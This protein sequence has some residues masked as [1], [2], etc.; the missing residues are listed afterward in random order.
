MMSVARSCD[1]NHRATFWSRGRGE[2]VDDKIGS[3][4]KFDRADDVYRLEANVPE[5][6]VYELGKASV[7]G[8]SGLGM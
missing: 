8:F 1:A 3:I 5:S 4:A 2:I 7:A 6:N